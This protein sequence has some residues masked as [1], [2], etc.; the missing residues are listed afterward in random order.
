M[1]KL[2]TGCLFFA[3]VA[4]PVWAEEAARPLPKH[5][6]QMNSA[7]R[8][9]WMYYRG[10]GTKPR[11]QKAY[12]WFEQ[13]AIAGDKQA[14]F[15]RALMLQRGRGVKQ[16]KERAFAIFYDLANTYADPH[17]AFQL[18]IAYE[19]GLGCEADE[20]QSARWLSVSAQNGV[21]PAQLKKGL[22]LLETK[23]K[24]GAAL[25]EQAAQNPRFRWAQ[26]Q[27]ALLYAEG[28]GI[29]QDKTKAFELMQHTAQ[30]GL[31]RAQWQLA[32]W[33]EQ[34]FGT[35][36]DQPQSFSWTLQAAQNGVLDAQRRVA[37]MYQ[38]GIGTPQNL[39]AAKKWEKQAA[40]T[41][42]KRPQKREEFY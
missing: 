36:A 23:P 14:L 17:A 31:P 11:Y 1:R 10:V 5:V 32:Q 29:K 24:E 15:F 34:G 22:S 37:E 13:G 12:Y 8:L 7:T 19:K 42:K 18:A 4:G 30:L 26:Y 33:Y 6:Q 9:G 39:K 20:K 21:P 28:T 3:L 38:N 2:I 35:T 25:I 41:A 16:D 27:L 40:K